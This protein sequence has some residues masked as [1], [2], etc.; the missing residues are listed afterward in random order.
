MKI[1]GK[2]VNNLAKLN[3]LEN[4]ENNESCNNFQCVSTYQKFDSILPD[5]HLKNNDVKF[6]KN[7]VYL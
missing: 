5:Y 6:F 1:A 4:E 7:L 2:I 3:S